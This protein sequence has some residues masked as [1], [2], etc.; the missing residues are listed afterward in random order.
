[1]MGGG[2]ALQLRLALDGPVVADIVPTHTATAAPS[3]T[4]GERLEALF[5]L[6]PLLH[7]VAFKLLTAVAWRDG[8]GAGFYGAGAHLGALATRTAHSD[9]ALRQAG[10]SLETTG[11]VVRHR[12][13]RRRGYTWRLSTIFASASPAAAERLALD[14][15]DT[16]PRRAK[17]R[18]PTVS[19]VDWRRALGEYYLQLAEALT[20]DEARALGALVRRAQSPGWRH[21]HL[22]AVDAY[23]RKEL[24]TMRGALA[25]APRILGGTGI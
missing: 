21:R 16:A 15:E 13:S 11:L 14:D 1:M 25:R 2:A 10:K 9:R 19:D 7:G 8:D 22:A 12:P 3:L 23:W 4:P 5:V 6:M 18:S 20:P 17:G 24:A